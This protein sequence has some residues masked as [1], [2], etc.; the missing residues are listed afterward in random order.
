MRAASAAPERARV[1]LEEALLAL[2]EGNYEFES[3]LKQSALRRARRRISRCI[4]ALLLVEDADER[5][6][7]LGWVERV[8]SELL[9]CI[10][11]LLRRSERLAR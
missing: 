11:G 3:A 2:S 7:C 8:E 6:T 1:W 4:A 5:P 9:S 10:A